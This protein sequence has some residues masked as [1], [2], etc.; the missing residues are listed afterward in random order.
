MKKEQPEAAM[1]NGK[2]ELKNEGG[3]GG[4]DE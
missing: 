1:K 4:C 3:L 2:R